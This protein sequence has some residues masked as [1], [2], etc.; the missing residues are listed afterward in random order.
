KILASLVDFVSQETAGKTPSVNNEDQCKEPAPTTKEDHVEVETHEE[1]SPGKPD[2]V[3][4][5]SDRLAGIK[6]GVAMA[7]Y[8]GARNEIFLL[9]MKVAMP[10][11]K[12]EMA[13]QMLAAVAEVNPHAQGCQERVQGC[14]NACSCVSMPPCRSRVCSVQ[15]NQAKWW[16]RHAGA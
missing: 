16:D 14:R 1:K 10:P 11:E 7:N 9:C 12:R 13:D 15:G 8:R 2:Y 4:E 5:L 3:M 6:E